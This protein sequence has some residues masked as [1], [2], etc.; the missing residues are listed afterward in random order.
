MSCQ[1]AHVD[2]GTVLRCNVVGVPKQGAPLYF[3]CCANPFIIVRRCPVGTIAPGNLSISDGLRRRFARKST[4]IDSLYSG[5][6]QYHIFV[7]LCGEVRSLSCHD[8]RLVSFRTQLQASILLSDPLF[9]CPVGPS[10]ISRHVRAG[11]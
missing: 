3:V 10:Y 11:G 4:A 5:K 7:I 6:Y 1:H 2:S 8:F 9:H